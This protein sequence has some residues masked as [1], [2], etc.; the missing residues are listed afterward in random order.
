MGRFLEPVSYSAL[1]LKVQ[2]FRTTTEKRAQNVGRPR[3]S[4]S[5]ATILL[6]NKGWIGSH[7]KEFCGLAVPQIIAPPGEK[8][9]DVQG[10]SGANGA[11]Q[12]F[13]SSV[14]AGKLVVRTKTATV[15]LGC[16]WELAC[17]L[18]DEDAVERIS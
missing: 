10:D 11:S 6:W 18:C 7:G 9:R 3:S 17:G 8:G 2:I 14:Q 5:L 16:S 12:T 13:E 15:E 4:F 1:V